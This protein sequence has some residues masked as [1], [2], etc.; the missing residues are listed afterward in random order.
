[1]RN[2]QYLSPETL[3]EALSI[4]EHYGGRARPLLGGTD[5]LVRIQKGQAEPEAVVDLKRVRDIDD[6]IEIEGGIT[7]IGARVV[8]FDLVRHERIRTT[9]PALVEAAS[10]VGSIQIRNR[11]TLVGNIC[12]ASPAADTVP[13][14]MIYGASVVVAASGDGGGGAI[15]R[16]QVPLREFFLEP[17]KTACSPSELVVAVHIPVPQEPFGSAFGRLTRRRGVDLATIN[18]ACSIDAEGLT[19]FVFGAAGPTPILA[20]DETGELADADLPQSRQDELLRSLLEKTSPISDVRSGKEYRQAMLLT[21]GRRV[22][23]Q[24]QA[25]RPKTRAG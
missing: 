15:D 24:A 25:R 16:R 13:P 12:N 14:L 23:R 20:R 2:Y 4:M 7:S 21:I 11:A 22:L 3:N 1:L 19:T 10:I 18:M 8:L 9:Y 17:G 5:L 6:R